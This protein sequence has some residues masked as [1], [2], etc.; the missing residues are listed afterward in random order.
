MRASL[1]V[2][3]VTNEPFVIYWVKKQNCFSDLWLTETSVSGKSRKRT[4]EV[5]LILLLK[6]GLSLSKAISTMVRDI[7]IIIFLSVLI[8]FF[9][10]FIL[11]TCLL[12]FI[13]T[14]WQEI[15]LGLLQGLTMTAEHLYTLP[16]LK[17]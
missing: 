17:C 12:G 14:K 9:N 7:T 5:Y 3:T 2:E 11:W 10:L 16:K 13:M 6:V 1:L 15:R 4:A 8:I